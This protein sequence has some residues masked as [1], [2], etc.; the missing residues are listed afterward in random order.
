MQAM[1]NRGLWIFLGV[2]IILGLL[3]QFVPLPNAEARLESLPLVGTQFGGKNIP[4]TDFEKKFFH[5][6]NILKRLYDVDDNYLFILAL[7]GTNNRHIVHDP[8]YCFKGSGWE[9]VNE[10]SIPIPLGNGALVK[11]R[12]GDKDKE[13]MFWFANGT[14]NYSSPLKY[15]WEATLR[16]LTFGYSGPEPV[17]VIIQPVNHDTIDWE[18][19]PKQF[20][21]L[22][23][24]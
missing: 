3:W 14:S 15:W 24:L 8:Y 19:L 12:K 16:R 23:K 13:A 4:L 9:I 10:K 5:N 18:M 17:L 20:P 21:S 7:D 6:V 11:I 22:F 1:S 2:V